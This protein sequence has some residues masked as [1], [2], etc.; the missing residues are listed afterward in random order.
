MSDDTDTGTA[1]APADA[2]ALSMLEG[3]K[4]LFDERVGLQP[5]RV[6]PAGGARER[7]SDVR[8]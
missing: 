3:M 6:V 4:V 5:V 8:D 7:E 1:A 2:P